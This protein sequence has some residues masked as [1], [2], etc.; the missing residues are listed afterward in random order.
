VAVFKLW[1]WDRGLIIPHLK[2]DMLQNVTEVPR[3]E[4]NFETVEATEN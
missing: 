2:T 4:F 1:D 3:L